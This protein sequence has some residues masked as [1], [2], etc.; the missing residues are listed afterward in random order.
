MMSSLSQ[1][2]KDNN[3]AQPTA[4][5]LN[6]LK[7][8]RWM[9]YLKKKISVEI[10]AAFLFFWMGYLKTAVSFHVQVPELFYAVYV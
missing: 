4:A 3:G 1:R 5:R 8:S 9:R 2:K 6:L 10:T 7:F